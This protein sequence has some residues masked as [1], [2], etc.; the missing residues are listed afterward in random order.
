MA[1]AGSILK[2]SIGGIEYDV[3]GDTDINFQ[4]SGQKI[5]LKP[6]SGKPIV[7]STKQIQAI[8]GLKLIGTLVDYDQLASIQEAGSPVPIFVQ[9]A[10]GSSAQIVGLIDIT[11]TSSMNGTID[12]DITPTERVTITAG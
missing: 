6:T 4:P 2:C 3:P 10:D 11:G 1:K 8:T 7:I 9:Y 5:E 12:V